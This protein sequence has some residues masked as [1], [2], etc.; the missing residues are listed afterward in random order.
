MPTVGSAPR[1][2]RAA[3]ATP[4]PAPS[5]WTF[6]TN[7]AHVLLCLAGDPEL[8]LRDVAERVGITERGVQKIVQELED[9]GAI[10]RSREGRRNRYQVH[11]GHHLHHPIEAHC[12][13]GDLFR[14][15]LG[16]AAPA[17]SR[18]GGR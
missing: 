10:T 8:R 2:N 15:V 11:P 4:A 12:T 6:F 1:P 17:A 13:I 5:S 14:L 7:H 3:R 9:A 16:D 18:R